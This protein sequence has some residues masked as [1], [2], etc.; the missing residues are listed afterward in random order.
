M[1]LLLEVDVGEG[2]AVPVVAPDAT[3]PLAVEGLPV[4]FDVTPVVA[5]EEREDVVLE[6]EEELE[7]NE[8]VWAT[9]MEEYAYSGKVL[10]F[11]SQE[12]R[13]ASAS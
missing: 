3:L 13:S 5:A 2:A 12:Q 8:A 1:P 7:V 10:L 9:L 6:E 4:G 11:K